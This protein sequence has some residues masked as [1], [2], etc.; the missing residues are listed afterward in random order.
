MTDVVRAASLLIPTIVAPFRES[1]P[2]TRLPE[3]E[4]TQLA[5]AMLE[6]VL[7]ACVEVGDTVVATAAI[8]LGA[9]VAAELATLPARP[10]A[11]VN[12]GDGLVVEARD[13]TTN[14]LA[15][16]RPSLVSLA[17]R[18]RQRCTLSHTR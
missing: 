5:R 2:E 3:R 6:D 15:F 11:I 17:L 4:R 7:A 1:S 13:G 12:A 9:A 16:S 10:V 18:A 8:G 14:A